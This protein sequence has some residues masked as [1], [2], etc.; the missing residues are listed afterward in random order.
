MFYALK[1]FYVVGVI[2]PKSFD[3][4]NIF[5]FLQKSKVMDKQRQYVVDD[6]NWA[7]MT[8]MIVNKS[9]SI[10]TLMQG[11]G[12][13]HPMG[14]KEEKE[15]GDSRK[16][17]PSEI[18]PPVVQEPIAPVQKVM[19]DTDSSMSEKEDVN[20]AKDLKGNGGI[21]GRGKKAVSRRSRTVSREEEPVSSSN[22]YEKKCQVYFSSDMYCDLKSLCFLRRVNVSTYIRRLVEEELKKYSKAIKEFNRYSESLV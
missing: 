18:V 13:S 16:D 2:T 10:E 20:D 15:G 1:G 8:S 7:D 6:E 17:S 4:Q 3:I 22:L 14:K 11:K 19:P 5:V 21:E 12:F 9:D